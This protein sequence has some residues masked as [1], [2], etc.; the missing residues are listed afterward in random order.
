MLSKCIA[1][2][3]YILCIVSFKTGSFN[4]KIMWE[5]HLLTNVSTTS[6][7]VSCH[8]AFVLKYNVALSSGKDNVSNLLPAWIVEYDA[9]ENEAVRKIIVNMGSRVFKIL[10]STTE[11]WRSSGDS[12]PS[13]RLT[14]VDF[15]FKAQVKIF[16]SLEFCPP[17]QM[18]KQ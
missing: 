17:E 13:A 12:I 4:A 11:A 14:D 8:L 5:N 9:V 16:S 18:M 15:L 2:N 7:V 1:F 3:N 6:R 10:Q